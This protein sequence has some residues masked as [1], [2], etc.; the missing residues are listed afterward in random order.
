LETSGIAPLVREYIGDPVLIKHAAFIKRHKEESFIPLHQ[1]SALWERPYKTAITVWVALTD[2]K[3]SNGG[4]FYYPYIE[5]L[6]PHEF[7]LRYPSF[8]CIPCD[9]LKIGDE[10]LK[11]IEVSSGSIVIWPANLP[12]GSYS[13]ISGQFRLGMPMVFV[14]KSELE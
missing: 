8:K 14:S 4:M 2:S 5:N 6:F 7:D 12:H 9:R 1:D 13:N 11:P 3:K 10:D